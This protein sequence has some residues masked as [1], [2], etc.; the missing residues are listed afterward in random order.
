[1][2][3]VTLRTQRVSRNPAAF[4]TKK[5]DALNGHYLRRLEPADFARRAVPF[6]RAAGFGDADQKLLA[7]PPHW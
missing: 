1:V 6:V 7:R 4:D 3:D 5:L 2:S